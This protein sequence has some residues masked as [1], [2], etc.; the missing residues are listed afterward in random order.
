MNK[1]GV[2]TPEQ[3]DENTTYFWNKVVGADAS[4]SNKEECKKIVQKTVNY[5]GS[6]GSGKKFSED[7]FNSTYKK[8]DP[9]GLEK[10]VKAVV[11]VMVTSMASM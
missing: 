2:Y 9:L 5:L 3:V 11:T 10:N 6:L 8:G 4:V 1:K 7:E